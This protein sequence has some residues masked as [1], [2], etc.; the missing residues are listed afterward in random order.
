MRVWDPRLAKAGEQA[1]IDYGQLG[2]WLNPMT[3]EA[4]KVW[5]FVMVLC[6]S[7]HM[8]V[9]PVQKMDRRA[10]TEC[11]VAAFAFFS[12]V[13]VRHVPAYVARHIIHVLW[14][15]RH[16]PGGLLAGAD[17]G[18]LAVTGIGGHITITARRAS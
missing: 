18:L 11:H 7:R 8:F 10:L 15:P 5:A 17:R 9:R 6:C 12:G 14:P 3:G 4:A 13:P 1:Q 2:R 16:M